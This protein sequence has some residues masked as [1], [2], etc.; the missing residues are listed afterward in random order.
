MEKGACMRCVRLAMVMAVLL[1]A[2]ARA[3]PIPVTVASAEGGFKI[4]GMV[5]DSA[6]NLGT[7]VMPSVSSVGDLLISGF[8]TNQDVIVSF[9]LEGLGRFDTLRL[10]VFNPSG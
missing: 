2:A 5:V 7:I 8:R 1:P 10:E 9:M 3:E 4:R 6:L